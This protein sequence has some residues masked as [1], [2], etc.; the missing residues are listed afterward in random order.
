MSL[1]HLHEEVA[2]ASERWESLG[3]QWRSLTALWLWAESALSKS[4][5]TDLS[6]TQIRKASLP[7][8]WKEWMDAKLMKTDAKC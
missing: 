8:E 2:L 4:G 3:A 1:L 5:H 6:F 7:E